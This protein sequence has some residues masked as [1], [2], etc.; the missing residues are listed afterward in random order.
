[1][2][3]Y[4][5][6]LNYFRSTLQGKGGRFSTGPVSFFLLFFIIICS[7]FFFCLNFLFSSLCLSLFSFSFQIMSKRK[8]RKHMG[9]I[10]GWWERDFGCVDGWFWCDIFVV[11]NTRSTEKRYRT[12]VVRSR[13]KEIITLLNCLINNRTAIVL[14]ITHFLLLFSL[15]YSSSTLSGSWILSVTWAY[16][17]SVMIGISGYKPW[18]AFQ[19]E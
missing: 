17:A 16:T 11:K 19:T 15:P 9:E 8:K 10:L 2:R 12:V 1:M 5:F 7:S 18:M 13:I 6:S 14:R 3:I 4:L